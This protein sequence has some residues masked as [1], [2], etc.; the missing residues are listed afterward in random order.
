MRNVWGNFDV[1]H[2]GDF[3]ALFAP[4]AS[5]ERVLFG[6]QISFQVIEEVRIIVINPRTTIAAASVL[7]DCLVLEL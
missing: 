3:P 7:G 4:E 6:F 1:L 5:L 2:R